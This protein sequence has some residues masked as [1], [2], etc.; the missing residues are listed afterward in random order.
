MNLGKNIRYL[1]LLIHSLSLF[2]HEIGATLHQKIILQIAK[3]MILYIG[4]QAENSQRV[5]FSLV[6]HVL[7]NDLL[8][9]I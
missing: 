7:N 1:L 8:P 9:I 3:I 6:N 4:T 2:T 5:H